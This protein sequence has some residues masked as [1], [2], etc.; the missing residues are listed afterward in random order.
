[1]NATQQ[2][3]ERQTVNMKHA[4]GHP[5][6]TNLKVN[7]TNLRNKHQKQSL[8]FMGYEMVLNGVM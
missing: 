3:C 7:R 6:I 1:V 5:F 8:T 4:S 2:Q